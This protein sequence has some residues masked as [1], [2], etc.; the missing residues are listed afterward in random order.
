MQSPIRATIRYPSGSAPHLAQWAIHVAAAFGASHADSRL[1][2]SCRYLD[3][4]FGS[5]DRI[6]AFIAAIESNP[7]CSVSIGRS[8]EAIVS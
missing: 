7:G 1:D 5:A 6:S 8:V 2:N 4:N 3:F